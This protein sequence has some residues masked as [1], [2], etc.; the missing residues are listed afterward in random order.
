MADV[1]GI[2]NAIEAA[3]YTNGAELITGDIL[4]AVLETMVNGLNTLKEDTLTF[5]NT[6]TNGSSNPV[7]S[8]GV[9]TALEGKQNNVNLLRFGW[10]G[11]KYLAISA[12]VVVGPAVRLD[13]DFDGQGVGSLV[14]NTQG[15]NLVA[16]YYGTTLASKIAKV[17][18]YTDD[19]GANWYV[20]EGA[21]TPSGWLCF[22]TPFRGL[23][24][25]VKSESD[26]SAWTEGAVASVVEL[27]AGGGSDVFW[28]T[29]N[30]TTASEIEAALTAGK[31]VGVIYSDKAY[32]FAA[33]TSQYYY[34]CNVYANLLATLRINRNTNEWLYYS[35]GLEITGNKNSSIVGHEN[36]TTRYPNN[37]ALT[38]A[39]GKMGVI[40]QTQTWSGT[41]SNPR[42]YVMSDQVTGLIPQSFIDLA[43]SI[44]ATFDSVTG[45]FKMNGLTDISY[46]EMRAIYNSKG[47]VDVQGSAG[48]QMF[49]VL[50]SG[51]R[52]LPG[53]NTGAGTKKFSFAFAFC[54]YLESVAFSKGLI[55]NMEAFARAAL[56]LKAILGTIENYATSFSNTF[57]NCY[58]LE[59]LS[60]KSLNA[61]ISFEQ[62]SL[63]TPASVAYM[64]NNAGTATF[65]ITLHATAYAAAN[66]DAAVTAA[67]AAHTN[68]TLASA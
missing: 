6:P 41:G 18:K 37:M 25:T 11:K 20:V 51:V 9:Y 17:S 33:Q 43:T 65:T 10:I 35:A 24:L 57:L 46:V 1:S 44:G 50:G 47:L 39:I 63:L 12:G 32:I 42:T 2:I 23:A 60:I 5:D 58:S 53:F 22:V 59:T 28:A 27:G 61:N 38:A 16:F 26:I 13:I 52:T 55:S 29:F 3:I 14:I 62:S 49:D 54:E 66:A 45:Y 30:S 8:G 4:Q 31:I 67:L 34:F 48:S 40:S 21:E 7:K 36:D 19:N 68:V 64:I 56:R 15:G